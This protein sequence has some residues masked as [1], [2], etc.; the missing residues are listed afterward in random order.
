M[1]YM[2]LQA[3]FILRRG[4]VP[5]NSRANQNHANPAQNSNLK[6]CISWSQGI[7]TSSYIAYDYNTSGHTDL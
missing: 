6:Q 1:C 2:E 5:A 3:G 7:T 4:H